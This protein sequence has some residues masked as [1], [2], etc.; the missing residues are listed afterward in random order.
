MEAKTSRIFGIRAVLEAIH[1]NNSIDKVFVQKESSG[2][3]MQELMQTLKKNNIAFSYVPVEKLDK[4]SK[5]N[6]HQ[7]A[8]AQIQGS[9]TKDRGPGAKP[10]DNNVLNASFCRRPLYHATI[11]VI[12][13]A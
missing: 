7:G 9:D 4:L 8:V 2:A 3:L 1:G 5:Y 12:G 11:S 13:Q 6:N 10:R